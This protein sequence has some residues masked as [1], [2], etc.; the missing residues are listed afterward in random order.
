MTDHL[1]DLADAQVIGLVVIEGLIFIALVALRPHTTKKGDWLSATL[2]LFRLVAT[3][4]LIS[5]F[6]SLGANEIT[7]TVL[8]I[9]IVAVWGFAVLLLFFSLLYNRATSFNRL[10]SSHYQLTNPPLS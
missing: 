7:K 2:S 8:G 9:V 5:F 3:G 10:L 1:I 6:P 4:L